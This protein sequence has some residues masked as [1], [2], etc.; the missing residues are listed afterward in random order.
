MATKKAQEEILVTTPNIPIMYTDSIFM[1]VN[2]DG[3][4]IDIC[5][6]GISQNQLQIVARVGMSKEHAKKF[7]K[8]LSEILALTTT[9]SE[10]TKG[11]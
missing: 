10:T 9:R 4:T 5:Q 6:K 8:R 7:V 2:E 1:N 3:V 11:N